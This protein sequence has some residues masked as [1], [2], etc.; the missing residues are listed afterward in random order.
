MPIGYEYDTYFC[1]CGKSTFES[2]MVSHRDGMVEMECCKEEKC[3]KE[4]PPKEK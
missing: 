2:C 4:D 3:Q 1:K